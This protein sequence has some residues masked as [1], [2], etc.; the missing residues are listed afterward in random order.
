MRTWRWL[1]VVF[2][3][4]GTVAVLFSASGAPVASAQGATPVSGPVATPVSGAV[5]CTSLFGIAPGNAC[6]L[7]LHGAAGLGPVNVF[8]DGQP[9]VGGATYGAL[10]DFVPVIAGERQVQVVPSGQTRQNAV[11][12]AT[13]VLEDGVA[14]E[15]AV[16]GP[17]DDIRLQVLPVDTRPLPEGVSR[18]RVIHASPD[19]PAI[20]FALLDGEPVIANLEPGDV[21]DYEELQVALYDFEARIAGTTEPGVPMPGVLMRP[22]TVY[23][24]YVTGLVED[25]SLSATLV[26]VL[27]SPDIAAATPVA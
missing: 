8:I 25:G 13:V 12:D 11:I 4:L 9:A 23:S 21:S 27:V 26:P 14:Y 3:I 7:V 5:P 10:G 19:A 22:N 1:P 16:L 18:L 20:D 2:T 6:V 24:V 15:V 17:A